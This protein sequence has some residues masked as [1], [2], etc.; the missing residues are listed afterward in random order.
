MNGF[1]PGLSGLTLLLFGL[2]RF[3]LGFS[4]L[5]W[6]LM[7]FIGLYWVLLAQI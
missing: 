2:I 3:W 4:G 1:L 6:V 5:D 7:G